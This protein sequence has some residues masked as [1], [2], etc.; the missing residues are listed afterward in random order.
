MWTFAKQF[1]K[2]GKAIE[3]KD[4]FLQKT[5]TTTNKQKLGRSLGPIP[6]RGKSET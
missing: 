3:D 1:F 5:T 6:G 2:L 4:E